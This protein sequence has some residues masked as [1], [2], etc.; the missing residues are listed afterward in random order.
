MGLWAADAGVDLVIAYGPLSEATAKAAAERGVATLHCTD[1]QEVVGYV[2]Q[3]V[4][5]GDA[6]LAKASHAMQLEEILARFY[7]TVQ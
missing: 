7:Q 6:L 3:N 5:A 2:R 4:H 1:P